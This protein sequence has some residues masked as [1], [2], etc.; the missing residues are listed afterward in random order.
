MLS[1]TYAEAHYWKPAINTALRFYAPKI[2]REKSEIGKLLMR[3]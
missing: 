2:T 1:K 3:N